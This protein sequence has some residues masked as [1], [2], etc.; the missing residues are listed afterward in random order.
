MSVNMDPNLSIDSTH[1]D[2]V[3]SRLFTNN[4]ST[5]D[6]LFNQ[7]HDEI[8]QRN[9]FSSRISHN[10]LCKYKTDTSVYKIISKIVVLNPSVLTSVHTFV[11]RPYNRLCHC[12]AW[13]YGI[14]LASSTVKCSGCHRNIRSSVHTCK[15]YDLFPRDAWLGKHNNH[16]YSEIRRK[17]FES[18][19]GRLPYMLPESVKLC[20][21]KLVPS[22]QSLEFLDKL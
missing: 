13:K 8:S 12:T 17:N 10:R 5:S 14:V 19:A 4:D 18:L 22:C 20:S 7:E 15:T 2:D 6:D 21:G 9:P 16:I 11:Q 3:T 1:S